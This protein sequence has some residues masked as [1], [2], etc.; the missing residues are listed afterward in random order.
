MIVRGGGFVV[1]VPPGWDVRIGSTSNGESGTPVQPLLHAA[2]FP[3]PE[4]RGEYGSR[5]VEAMAAPHAFVSLIDFGP[6]SVGT[7]LFA[8]QGV[9]RRLRPDWFDPH[10]LQRALPGQGGMQSFQTEAGRA[11]CLYVVLGGHANRMRLVPSVNELLAGLT[12]LP[13]GAP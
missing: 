8:A 2:N 6:E 3:L 7:A 9:P 1:D 13:P 11:L 12:I 5:V 10:Q 4:R